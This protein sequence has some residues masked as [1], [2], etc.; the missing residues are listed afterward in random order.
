MLNILWLSAIGALIGA[1]PSLIVIILKRNDVP[2]VKHQITTGIVFFFLGFAWMSLFLYTSCKALT[3][4]TVIMWMWPVTLVNLLGVLFSDYDSYSSDAIVTG[5]IFSISLVTFISSLLVAPVQNLIYDHDAEDIDITYTISSDEILAR[6]DID[7]LNGGKTP[8]SDKFSVD[9]PEM[10]RIGEKDIAVYH[11]RDKAAESDYSEYIPGYIIMEK[12]ELPKIISKRIY[13][14]YS[15]VH[16]KDAL[17]TVRRSFPT[18][19][20]GDH[21][22]DVDDEY[23][24]YEIYEYRENLFFSTGRDYGIITLNLQDGTVAKYLAEDVP[25]WGDFKTTYPK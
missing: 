11:I 3:V 23:N 4:L 15:Y 17:R 14:D 5:I 20:L 1:L 12:G 2:Y 24:P 21:K 16:K 8:S 10:R 25:A 19:Y 6:L 22:F 9:A 18:V 7:I 13:F